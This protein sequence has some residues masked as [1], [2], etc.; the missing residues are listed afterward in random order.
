MPVKTF[1]VPL[2]I[3]EQLKH[4][5]FGSSINPAGHKQEVELTFKDQ[6]KVG[7]HT[8]VFCEIFATPV[9]FPIPVQDMHFPV[10]SMYELASGQIQVFLLGWKMKL[11]LHSHALEL[12]GL[13]FPVLLARFVQVKHLPL[14]S[15]MELAGQKQD[16][17]LVL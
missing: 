10:E 8:Q 2:A 11:G 1:P 6:T 4:L 14:I 16:V 15:I 5:P 9:L 7:V 17:V 3:K 12:A 13:T